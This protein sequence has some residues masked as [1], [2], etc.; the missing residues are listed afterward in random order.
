M[1]WLMTK[2]MGHLLRV[3]KLCPMLSKHCA[4]RYFIIYIIVLKKDQTFSN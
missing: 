3:V 2:D 4:K 1:L